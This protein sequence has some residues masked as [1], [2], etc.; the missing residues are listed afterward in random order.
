M[1]ENSDD[2]C[3]PHGCSRG[4]VSRRQL[5][6]HD[7]TSPW[8]S[9]PRGCRP[10]IQDPAADLHRQALSSIDGKGPSLT[11][12]PLS[13]PPSFTP[14]PRELASNPWPR[15]KSSSCIHF[16]SN[17]SETASFTFCLSFLSESSSPD[18]LRHATEIPWLFVVDLR[19]CGHIMPPYLLNTWFS[20]AFECSKLTF[21][22]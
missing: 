14:S 22:V 3:T 6:F 4:A 11:R 13:F 5:V 17:L 15:A 1:Y 2:Q 12:G 20:V 8:L 10:C 16:P 21:W 18:L 9:R 7:R 19:H